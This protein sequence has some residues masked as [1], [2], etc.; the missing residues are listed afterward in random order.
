MLAANSRVWLA[1]VPAMVVPFVASLFYF[2][3]LSG[4]DFAV[5]LYAA[6]KAFIVVWPLISVRLIL[7]THLPKVKLTL[8][9]HRQ[10]IP[11]GV[12]LGIAIVVLMF[13]LM[14]TPLG[15]VVSR[16]SESISRKAQQFGVLKHYWLFAL[17][18]SFIH[19]LMEEYY[20]RWFVFGRLKNVVNVPCAHAIAGVSFAAHH[21]VVATQFFPVLWGFLFGA[22]AGAGGILWSVMYDKQKTLLGAWLCH[23]IVDF[24]IMAIG[25][26]IL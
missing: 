12:F 9:K 13:G 4:C 8:A 2:V 1:L 15:E 11:L 17:F 21:V 25:Y 16:S 26:S 10:A 20:W 19:S 24:G 14:R 5:V 7:R 22:L 23:L 6:A 18:L 3:I